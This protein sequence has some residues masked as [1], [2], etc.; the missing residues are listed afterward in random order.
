MEDFMNVISIFGHLIRA[1]GFLALGFAVGKF[2]TTEFKQSVWQVQ[3]AL[4]LGF[5][6]LLAGLTHFASAGSMG[7][8]ALTAGAA[9]ILPDLAKKHEE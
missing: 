5:F 8:F 9:M 1:I 6:G 4:V 7:A 3:V 2:F